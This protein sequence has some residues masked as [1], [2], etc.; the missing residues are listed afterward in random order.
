MGKHF[1]N[2]NCIKF[3]EKPD[4]L[5]NLSHTINE[6]KEYIRENLPNN[7][8]TSELNEF[9]EVLDE[10][11][12]IQSQYN[13]MDFVNELFGLEKQ[14]FKLRNE[15][16][17]VPSFKS[18]QKRIIEYADFHKQDLS[19]DDKKV[20]SFLYTATMSK[21]GSI[22]N[23]SEN[24]STVD[25]TKYLELI[26]DRINKLNE[27]ERKAV[28]KEYQEQ[29]NQ[30]LQIKIK[31]A[32]EL[33][34]KQILPEIEKS[35]AENEVQIAQLIRE[36]TENRRINEEQR[37]K[38]LMH[39]RTILFWLKTVGYFVLFCVATGVIMGLLT[40]VHGFFAP[41]FGEHK[42]LT[43]YD[44]HFNCAITTNEFFLQSKMLKRQS[45]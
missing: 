19:D 31:L 32:K 30:S 40:A 29:F 37:L 39:K 22:Q 4:P 12:S 2:I 38:E 26:K 1:L 44:K 15:L 8:R 13:P 36:I 24:V 35:F 21:L 17:F 11:K 7:I 20:L 18:L 25:L 6:Y 33:I 5:V 3:P 23:R 16:S 10:N 43:I 9:I 42:Q 41:F 14:Y 27:M 45:M 28:I 34:E